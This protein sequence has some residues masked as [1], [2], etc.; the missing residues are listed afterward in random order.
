MS[1][2]FIV[3]FIVHIYSWL[4]V[5]LKYVAKHFHIK[6]HTFIQNFMIIKKAEVE[7]AYKSNNK[8]CI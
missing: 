6:L 1:E 8:T 3:V 7:I 4:F 2:T 5:W